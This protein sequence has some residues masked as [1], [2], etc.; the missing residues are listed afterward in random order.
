[1]QYHSRVCI[2]DVIPLIKDSADSD[3]DF[4]L[5]IRTAFYYFFLIIVHILKNKHN[6]YISKLS[7]NS[8]KIK[9]HCNCLLM[10]IHIYENPMN[11]QYL[12]ASDNV[13][14]FPSY[15]LPE[16]FIQTLLYADKTFTIQLYAC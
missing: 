9:K 8:A 4:H 13:A 1:M 12:A 5:E 2:W 10:F 11:N 16:L 15:L 6:V 14:T 7:L 3:Q